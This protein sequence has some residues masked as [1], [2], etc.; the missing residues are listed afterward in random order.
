MCSC[1]CPYLPAGLLARPSSRPPFWI[2]DLLFTVTFY[3]GEPRERVRLADLVSCRAESCL[4]AIGGPGLPPAIASVHP[5]LRV[6]LLDSPLHLHS[7]KGICQ[8]DEQSELKSYAYSQAITS[9]SVLS[10]QEY[11]WSRREQAVTPPL[12]PPPSLLSPTLASH[13]PH[14]LFDAVQQERAGGKGSLKDA[15]ETEEMELYV[16][17]CCLINRNLMDKDGVR[18]VHACQRA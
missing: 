14:C 3:A 10:T 15:D 4:L 13:P 8:A 16:S 18:G 2:L 11:P 5:L 7:D 12:S 6:H 17:L 9:T 1:P